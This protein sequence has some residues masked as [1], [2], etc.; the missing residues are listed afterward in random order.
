[1][2]CQF[3]EATIK[4]LEGILKIY[5]QAVANKFQTADTRPVERMELIHWFGAG[6]M[7][8]IPLIVAIENEK[9]LGWGKIV[10]YRKGREALSSAGE[11][12]F[13]VDESCTGQGVGSMLLEKLISVA[14]NRGYK[15][16]FAI[17]IHLNK[18]SIS[19]LTKYGFDLWGTLPDIGEMDGIVFSHCYYG[20][21]V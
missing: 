13:Y 14:G 3:R 2:P 20:R 5:N 1:M 17:V 12:S 18:R 19:L 11:I 8:V 21:K 10:D 7:P 15:T 4:D 9:L 16:V 6:G